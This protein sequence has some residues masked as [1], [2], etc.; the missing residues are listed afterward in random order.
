MGMFYGLNNAWDAS[1]RNVILESD[2]V[3]A[4]QL[5]KTSIREHHPWERLVPKIKELISIY[6]F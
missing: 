5:V 4:V 3:E 2:S 1:F 6:L